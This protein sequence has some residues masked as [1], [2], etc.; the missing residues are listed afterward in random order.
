MNLDKIKVLLVDD[1]V[2]IREGIRQILELEDDIKVIC[3]ASDGEE[4][5]QKALELKPDVILLDIN[6]PNVSGIE[7]LRKLKDIGIDSKIIMLTI[8]DDR[9]YI[10]RTL[11]LGAD[12]YIVKDSNADS[13]IKAIRHV[14]K[15]KTYIQP[16]IAEVVESLKEDNYKDANI[17]KINSLTRRE[18]EVLTLISEGLNNKAI[19]NEIFI[20]EKTV[21]NHISSIFKKLE[22]ND[23]V[24]ATIFSFKNG[25]KKI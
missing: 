25:I 4:G 14:M 12:G 20:S 8:H 18:F 21:K 5:Y 2:L 1:H 16:R 11:N 23:R 6:M 3:Q 19:A 17:E 22:L 13:F 10:L 9:E 24:Q 7:T 15:G